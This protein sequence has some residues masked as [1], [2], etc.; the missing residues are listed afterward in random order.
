M[1]TVSGICVCALMMLSPLCGGEMTAVETDKTIEIR[2]E[3][4]TFLTYH[5]AEVSPPEGADPAYKRSGFIH[6]VKTPQGAI[7]TGI[8]PSDHYHHLGLWHAWVKTKHDGEFVDFWNLKAKTGRVAFRKTVSVT[9]GNDV[10]GFVVEQDHIAYKGEEKRP[11]VVLHEVFTVR[12]RLV[13]GAFEIDYETVQKN[14]SDHDLEL[15]AYRY[16]GP[17]AYRAPHHWKNGNSNY[18]SSEGKTRVDG[19]TTR[20]RW[21]S[22]WGPSVDE[23]G[24]SPASLTIM[25]YPGNRDAPQR[26]RVWPPK[27]NDGAIFFNYVPAQEHA[28]SIRSG[29]SSVMKYR[30]V[31]SDSQSDPDSINTRWSRYTM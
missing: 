3:G 20:S 18:L 2:H 23:D 8:H 27:T 19:H 7:V 13:D 30:I 26:M 15:P 5:K 28:M 29:E 25:G 22:M 12:A 6:P 10:A 11:V 24:S 17:I 14:V 1:K 4:A 16:G 21:I 9:G 31:V